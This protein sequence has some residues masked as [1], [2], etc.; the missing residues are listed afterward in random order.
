M[1]D[2][3]RAA[4][5]L[6]L[7]ILS[8]TALLASGCSE[9]EGLLPF[10]SEYSRRTQG[11]DD[12]SVRPYG[13]VRAPK[14]ASTIRLKAT[15]VVGSPDSRAVI[16]TDPEGA[17]VIWEGGDVI[18]VQFLKDGVFY[19]GNLVTE[20]GGTST[21]EFTTED[22]ILGGTD[23]IFFTPCY[24]KFRETNYLTGKRIFGLEVPAAQTAVPDGVMAGSNLAFARSDS[25][26][27]GMSINFT[28]LPALLRF[29]L[30][31]DIASDVKEVILRTTSVIAGDVLIYDAD[32]YPDFHPGRIKD[33]DTTYS[34]ITLS[35]DFETG[36]EYHIAL[37]PRE[38][39]FFEMEFSDGVGHGNGHSTTLRSSQKITLGRSVVTDI[40]PIDLGDSFMGSGA[41]STAPVKYMSAT[42]GT[43]PVSVAVVPDGFTLAELPLYESLAKSALDFLFDTEPYKTYKNRF[44]AW[45]LK[46][47][48][49]QS[50]AGVTDGNG[51]VV[52]PVNNYFGTKWGANSYGD[53]RADDNKVFNF[54]T[55]NCPDIKSNI[56]TIDEVPVIIIVNDSRYAGRAWFWSSGKSYCMCPW[57]HNG[58]STYWSHPV[59]VPDSESDPE[60]GWHY[61]TEADLDSWG[62]SYGDWRNAVI[63]EFGHSFGRL[64][65]EYWGKKPNTAYENERATL[66]SLQSWQ[67]PCGLNVS[68]S[69]SNTPWD[70]FLDKRDELIGHDTRYSKIGVFQGGYTYLFGMWR[71]EMVS[72]MQDNRQYFNAWSRYL[73]AKRI[74]TLSGDLSL[75][76]FN[77][78][79]ERDVTIDPLRDDPETR[80]DL[81]RSGRYYY[82]YPHDPEEFL[83]PDAPVGIVD[84]SPVPP[85]I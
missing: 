67:V 81:D 71:S 48:S 30:A 11:R 43:K 74:M 65:D 6:T 55:A 76:N 40:G 35:G 5:R 85:G 49:N 66:K 63:H 27:D 26:E 28:N 13:E 84:D 18:R 39:S 34:S 79:L 4:M 56:H 46:V 31:G 60:G 23:Y 37:W 61:P 69:Y 64:L 58:G 8:A 42:E 12:A 41:I 10:N 3:Y 36:K 24:K 59:I 75:F 1:S 20:E 32:G 50:G 25:F 44:N 78:W 14:G 83:P 9:T 73:I 68:S 47:A 53:M 54:V 16:E 45:I 2:T 80:S 52:T 15:S 29:S 19:Y 17:S 38:L 51:N 21:A 33:V 57:F 82:I 72:G 62:R 7:A 70:E 77:Y 22:D